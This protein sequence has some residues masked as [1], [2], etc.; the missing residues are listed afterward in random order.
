MVGTG[1]WF[2]DPACGGRVDRFRRRD[3]SIG[4]T[5]AYTITLVQVTE[6]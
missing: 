2:D 1:D 5:G 6:E 4:N 3:D